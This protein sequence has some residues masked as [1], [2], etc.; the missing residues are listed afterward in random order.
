MIADGMTKEQCDEIVGFSGEIYKSYKYAEGSGLGAGGYFVRWKKGSSEISA[1]FDNG[2]LI[3][4][5]NE[6]L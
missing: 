6:N 1:Q 5:F 3:L 4:K 2:S